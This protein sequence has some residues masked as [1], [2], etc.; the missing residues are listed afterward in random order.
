MCDYADVPSS[1]LIPCLIGATSVW[2]FNRYL[3][4]LCVCVRA[5]AKLKVQGEATDSR[6]VVSGGVPP[7]QGVAQSSG[8][9]SELAGGRTCGFAM[10]RVAR[11]PPSPLPH[12]VR[13]QRP[14]PA[15]PSTLHTSA[16]STLHLLLSLSP[17]PLDD[18]TS[19]PPLST[20]THT[21]T[22][23]CLHQPSHS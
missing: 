15:P 16:P 17:F 13:E 3:A 12:R 23:T 18:T 4:R 22:H 21:H 10:S 9:G 20:T 1:I 11:T 2:K 7:S 14:L 5:S 19:T 6:K 8:D